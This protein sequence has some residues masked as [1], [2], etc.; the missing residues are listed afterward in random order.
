M[1]REKIDFIFCEGGASTGFTRRSAPQCLMQYRVRP[2]L[3][4]SVTVLG[5]IV[6]T[7]DGGLGWN[8][9]KLRKRIRQ[10]NIERH[11]INCHLSGNI[12]LERCAQHE[13]NEFLG[14]GKLL[15]SL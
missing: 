11:R 13:V 14:E 2:G 1:R 9:S 6:C 7:Q 4:P 8:R 3:D 12:G 5:N 10:R 15:E